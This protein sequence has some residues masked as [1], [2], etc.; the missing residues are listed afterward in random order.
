MAINTIDP[1]ILFPQLNQLYG[2]NQTG[3]NVQTSAAQT[4][5]PEGPPRSGG[6]FN[7]LV[8]ALNQIGVATNT[9]STGV[10]SVSATDTSSSSGSLSQS[11]AQAVQ[12]FFQ[13]LMA[14]LQAQGGQPNSPGDTESNGAGISNGSAAGVGHHHGRHG[15]RSAMESLIQTLSSAPGTSSGSGPGPQSQ[16]TSGSAVGSL[17]QSFQNLVNAFGGSAGSSANLSNFLQA[18]VSHLPGAANAGQV[19]HTQA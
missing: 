10:G 9:A 18:L 17:Q 3:G 11:Q 8:Q 7:A 6:L 16:G 12:G 13:S 1:S 4:T 19:I 14:A 2:A 5:P 15:V